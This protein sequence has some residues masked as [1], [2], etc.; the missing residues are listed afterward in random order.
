MSETTANRE[1]AYFTTGML[2]GARHRFEVHAAGCS[3]LKQSKYHFVG[4]HDVVT[5][6]E[7]AEELVESEADY[8]ES[9]GQGYTAKDFKIFPCAK[10]LG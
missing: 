5:W 6:A 7:T 9:N 8:Y 3:H 2:R 4:P 10:K 1:F